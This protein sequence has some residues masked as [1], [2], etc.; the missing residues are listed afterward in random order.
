MKKYLLSAAMLVSTLALTSCLGGST[1]D[2]RL[3]YNYGGSECFNRVIDLQTGGE[4]IASAP[5]Y[6]LQYN[7]TAGNVDIALSNIILSQGASPLS[8]KFPTMTYSQDPNDGFIV[9]T[10]RSITP[11]NMGAS[12]YVFDQFNLRAYFGRAL[13]SVYYIRYQLDINNEPRYEVTT[14]A[15]RNA[16]IGPVSAT[17]LENPDEI[18]SNADNL[19]A[20]ADTYYVVLLNQEKRTATIQVYNGKYTDTMTPLTFMVKD[21]PFTFTPDGYSVVAGTDQP[22][23]VYTATSG[24][25]PAEGLGMTNVSIIGNLERG[26]TIRF[27][28]DLGDDGKYDV[29]ASLR[30]L[31]YNTNKN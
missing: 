14:Y 20:Q 24:E 23:P 5:T 17:N 13:G 16:Y 26:A 6:N 21:V 15:T 2:Q 22:L 25:N 1:D 7:T 19:Q 12:S 9:T 11:E 31:L 8:F 4:F 3:T 30:Y 18:Y 10:G 29:T 27:K 28:C